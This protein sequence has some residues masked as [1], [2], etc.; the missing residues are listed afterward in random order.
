[1]LVILPV[2]GL[3]PSS[4]VDSL[5]F[6]PIFI[7]YYHYS[8]TFFSDHHFAFLI[9]QFSIPFHRR[10]KTTCWCLEVVA[11]YLTGSGVG[12]LSG[13]GV[14]SLSGS[15]S[16]GIVREVSWHVLFF[17]YCEMFKCLLAICKCI[18]FINWCCQIVSLILFVCG[19]ICDNTS[20]QIRA[21]SMQFLCG[22]FVFIRTLF[23]PD[24]SRRQLEQLPLFNALMPLETFQFQAWYFTEANALAALG[25][26]LLPL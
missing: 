5:N 26:V 22:S 6:Q 23:R 9:T 3:T 4:G 2:L 19:N 1:M 10:I 17:L 18:S 21:E 13:S 25:I 11:R 20:W 7:Y 14:G 12:S 24:A 15:G 8:N 16:Y